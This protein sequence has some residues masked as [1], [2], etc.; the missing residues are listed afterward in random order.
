M[1]ESVPPIHTGG[2]VVLLSEAALISSHIRSSGI[3]TNDNKTAASSN[4]RHERQERGLSRVSYGF[5]VNINSKE[6]HVC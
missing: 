1:S 4:Q 5:L 3:S 6:R 2:A